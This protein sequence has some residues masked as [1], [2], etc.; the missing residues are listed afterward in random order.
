[1]IWVAKLWITIANP[2]TTDVMVHSHTRM[3]IG[4]NVVTLNICFKFSNKN[5]MLVQ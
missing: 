3:C 5:F 4:L 1:V 2:S